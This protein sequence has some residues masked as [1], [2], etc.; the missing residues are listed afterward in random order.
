MTEEQIKASLI[1]QLRAKGM[2]SAFYL[3]KVDEYM[4]FWRTRKL[5]EEDIDKRGVRIVQ[6]SG[7][8]F[9]KE[10]FNEAVRELPKLTTAMLSIL[11]SFGLQEPVDKEVTDGTDYL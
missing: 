1:D 11:K 7:N 9:E 5:L 8:G 6:R 10:M 4:T 2:T 3:D